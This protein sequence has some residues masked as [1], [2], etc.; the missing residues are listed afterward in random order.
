[1][2]SNMKRLLS[3]QLKILPLK[4]KLC[5]QLGFKDSS[6]SSTFDETLLIKR[7]SKTVE[8]FLTCV[9]LVYDILMCTCVCIKQDILSFKMPAVTL[10]RGKTTVNMRWLNIH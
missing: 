7:F 10:Y 1:M 5:V 6:A 2:T 4:N 9:M 8:L 3:P